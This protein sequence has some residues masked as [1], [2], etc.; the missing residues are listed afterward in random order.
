MKREGFLETDYTE[1]VEIYL[2]DK[3]V[4][5]Y[6]VYG[7]NI[8]SWTEF[9]RNFLEFFGGKD[10][11]LAAWK[12]LQK[13]KQ[14]DLSIMEFSSKLQIL[15]KA[16]KVTDSKEKLKYFI[17]SVNPSYRKSVY[18]KECKTWEEAL[19]VS[20][21]NE[22]LKILCSEE[23]S[24]FESQ[25]IDDTGGSE[26]VKPEISYPAQNDTIK[27]VI[28]GIKDIN[29]PDPM[30]ETLIK[31]FDEMNLNLINTVKTIQ[32][33]HIDRSNY[34]IR[35]N[36]RTYNYPGSGNYNNREH[37]MRN[38]L[39]FYCNEHGH[40][41]ANC[42]KRNEVKV[43]IPNQENIMGNKYIP[44]N[45]TVNCME[46]IDPDEIN[47][48]IP[49]TK[50]PESELYV[51]EKR[52]FD[53]Q[54]VGI[55]KKHK[56]NANDNEN[57]I[58]ANSKEIK[59]PIIRKTNKQTKFTS[60]DVPYSIKKEL[61]N[62]SANINLAQ[63]LE[64]SPQ[65]RKE[66]INYCRKGNELEIN[67]INSSNEWNTNCKTIVNVL[68]RNYWAVLD[69]GAACS[70]IS[71]SFAEHL[72]LLVDKKTSQQIVT[73]DGKRHPVEGII[74]EFP[75]TIAERDFP[76]DMIV[77]NQNS[78]ML[79]LGTNWIKRHSAIIDMNSNQLILSRDEYDIILTISI[80]KESYI[81][82]KDDNLELYGIGV[83]EN[84][85]DDENEIIENEELKILLT[86][87]EDM[88]ATE[89]CDLT[90]TDTVEHSII[91]GDA[92]PALAQE[93]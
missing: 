31:K 72:G 26:I 89:V 79:I 92:K 61:T 33:V 41:Q 74:S 3:A 42:P 4:Y 29:K 85:H 19:D 54:K 60:T 75:I 38:G 82:D 14:G 62:T 36:I 66:L 6:N 40:T 88:M 18:Q 46:L 58:E 9:K 10:R 17:V 34:P 52:K 43:A 25:K 51:A 1:F 37:F 23:L 32:N 71:S 30:Y 93:K 45:K 24:S 48:N 47:E 59:K 44:Q 11:E 28:S 84:Q 22:Q 49:E 21:K 7:A 63:L 73:A 8:D 56:I 53:K 5:W 64:T 27:N 68:G 16:A 86:Q 35:S 67:N 70:V 2:K 80:R 76:I 55:D 65:I 81:S 69:T 12:E 13:Y 90:Q 20:V 78:K 50:P 39:C 91:T 77:L 83:E 57:Q 15:F 87:Y